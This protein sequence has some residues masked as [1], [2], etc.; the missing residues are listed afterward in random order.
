MPGIKRLINLSFR[1]L[2]T[3]I[4]FSKRATNCGWGASA[5]ID[6]ERNLRKV[7]S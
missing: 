1:T 4:T 7:P 6:N 3:L 5:N 2:G